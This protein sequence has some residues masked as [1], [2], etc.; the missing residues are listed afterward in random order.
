MH[1]KVKYNNNTIIEIQS[2]SQRKRIKGND[3]FHQLEIKAK[4]KKKKKMC[5]K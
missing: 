2:I 1:Y 3:I 4:K 5:F